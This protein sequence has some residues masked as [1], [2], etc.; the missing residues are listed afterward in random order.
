M[1]L[2]GATQCERSPL[3]APTMMA[4]HGSVPPGSARAISRQIEWSWRGKI[5]EIGIETRGDGPAILLLPALSSI[6]TR[7]EMLPLA[8]RLSSTFT[9]IAV[10]WPGFGD[11]PRP[12][13]A[14][15]PDAYREFLGCILQE[16]PKP[17]ATV[18]AGHGAA[19]LLAHAAEHPGS[20]GS[21]CLV[22]PTWRGPLPTMMGGR[23]TILRF[24]SRL[25]DLPVI[26][27][28]LYALNVNK[29]MIRMMGRG[30]VYAEPAWLD[31]TRLA[32]KLVVT[33]A[34]G[35]RHASFR[36]VAGELDPMPTRESFLATARQVT[37][38]IFVVYGAAT[39]RR[40]KAEMEALRTLPNVQAHEL[41]AGKLAVHEE[42]P[43]LVADAVLSFIGR[44][45][46]DRGSG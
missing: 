39:P 41:P 20:V 36:F 3:E 26:G 12:A 23:S 9:T 37:D 13:I 11:R 4:A 8:E 15:G 2:F 22:A 42:F 44:S 32:E 34:P 28:A 18:A 24:V 27:S 40:S 30:H 43:G 46:D 1:P 14:W 45:A 6:S 38:P 29:P 35:A 33:N 16:L 21:L 19:Y 7:A 31:E 17:T 10:D 5:I 25:V